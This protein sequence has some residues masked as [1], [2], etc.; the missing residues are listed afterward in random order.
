[1]QD[2]QK[3]QDCVEN[4]KFWENE[5]KLGKVAAD[6]IKTLDKIHPH[7]LFNVQP[8]SYNLSIEREGDRGDDQKAKQKAKEKKKKDLMERKAGGAELIERELKENKNDLD[9]ADK[10][11][12]PV[13]Q[14]KIVSGKSM[15]NAN[16]EMSQAMEQMVQDGDFRS[17][18]IFSRGPEIE[19]TSMQD[20][21]M[22]K[23]LLAKIKIH[24]PTKTLERG[25]VMP[26]D[27]DNYR[28]EYP[29]AVDAYMYNPFKKEKE[30][31]KKKQKR[32]DEDIPSMVRRGLTKSKGPVDTTGWALELTDEKRYKVYEFGNYPYRS[33][34]RPRGDLF[35][36]MLPCDA[37][38]EGKDDPAKIEEREKAKQDKEAKL[39]KHKA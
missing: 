37:D 27:F 12:P 6:V 33:N 39:A 7:D 14:K 11:A 36:M 24:I 28:P 32:G 31:K 16:K 2:F 22:L 25:I 38:W 35:R 19:I 17:M 21:E 13:A 20:V 10:V 8:Q 23:Q 34:L 18:P 1:M 15:N 29:K 26:R 4:V 5:R 9:L 3:P 30:T